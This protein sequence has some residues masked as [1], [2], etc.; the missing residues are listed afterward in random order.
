MIYSFSK[1]NYGLNV[2]TTNN[3]LNFSEGGPELTVTLNSGSYTLGEF[4]DAID[5][6]LNSTGALDYNAT[7]NRATNVVTI[8]ASGPFNLLLN[9]GSNIGISFAG[10]A[11]F[12]Q[13][14]DLTGASSYV[15]RS[16]AGF[17]YRPQFLLQSYVPSSIFQ[18]SADAVVNKT[19]SGRVEVVR[20]GIEKYIE[21]DI[22]FV[23]NLPMDGVVI[24]N[25]PNGLQS[26]IDFLSDISQKTRFEFVP[27]I[28][29]P[30]VIEKV[31]LESSPS[32]SNGTGFK[33]RE[34]FS[35]KLP[36]IYDTGVIKLSV[37]R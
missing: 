30:N 18:Q 24:K 15:G 11:G 1:F 8:S 27:D 35:Q 9:S 6:G 21:M 37:V 12:T 31:I 4:V 3:K 5:S 33:L 10:L 19:A 28:N 14:T 36:D 20:F 26:C 13:T 7:L 17:E 32:Y 25:N 29:A 22:K 23:T 2:D 34:L 16:P